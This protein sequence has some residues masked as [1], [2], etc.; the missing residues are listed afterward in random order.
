MR[1]SHGVEAKIIFKEVLS[2]RQMTF[3][4]TNSQEIFNLVDKYCT[5][6]EAVM[7][8]GWAELACVGETYE[9]DL[10]KIEMVEE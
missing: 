5:T 9:A 2:R 6:D 7:A 3:Y 4:V 1:F 8:S 10:F